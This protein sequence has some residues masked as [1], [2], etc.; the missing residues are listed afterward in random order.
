MAKTKENQDSSILM[1]RDDLSSD[2]GKRL[3]WLFTHSIRGCCERATNPQLFSVLQ[4]KTRCHGFAAP[5]IYDAERG[6]AALR[7]WSF[8]PG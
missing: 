2:Q 4:L 7:A 5:R 8:R 3:P 1:E 6:V